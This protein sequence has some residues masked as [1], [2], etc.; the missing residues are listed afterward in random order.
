M[1]HVANIQ[2]AVSTRLDNGNHNDIDRDNDNVN[3]ND[4]DNE[5]D[6]DNDNDNDS[7]NINNNDYKCQH[8]FCSSYLAEG[9]ILLSAARGRQH[10][11]SASRLELHVCSKNK[12]CG[13]WPAG[14]HDDRPGGLE[15]SALR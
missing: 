6:N 14:F 13:I 4:N 5:N 1:S 3:N 11:R 7:N 12:N 10:L 9:C 15:F 8:G 2:K